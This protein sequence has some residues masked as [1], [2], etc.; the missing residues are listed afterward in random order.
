[1]DDA[2]ARAERLIEGLAVSR[3]VGIGRVVFFKDHSNHHMPSA[4]VES[5]IESE[6]DRFRSA[7]R[8]CV[9]QLNGLSLA[10][11]SPEHVADILSIQ[12]LIL[13][14]SSFAEK[15]ETS[16]REKRNTAE[17]AVKLVTADHVRQQSAVPD[18][19]LREKR[20][21]IEDVCRRMLS[22]LS[23][24]LSAD[25]SG[26]TGAVVAAYELRPSEIIELSRHKPAGIVTE[27]GG[28]TSHS[29]ILA[30]EFMIPMVSGV[31]GVSRII[32]ASEHTIVDGESGT[33]VLSPSL[34]TLDRYA[35]RS[36]GVGHFHQN[37]DAIESSLTLDKVRIRIRANVDIPEAYHLAKQFGAEGIGLFRSE[38]LIASPGS[39]PDEE[40]QF[41]AYRQI[42]EVAGDDRVRIRTFDIGLDRLRDSGLHSEINPSLGLRSIRLS[43]REQEH[44]RTQ[45]RAILRAS[46]DTKIDIVLPMV[47]G[48]SEVVRAKT[49]IDEERASLISRDVEVGDPRVGAM[50]E[51]PSGV[52]T[53]SEIAREV[54]FL[55]LGTNDLV[56]YLLAVDRDNDAVAEWYQTLHP[57]VMRAVSTVIGA[58]RTASVPMLI[59]GEMAGSPFYV[60]LL[61]GLGARELSMN[62]NSISQIR[63]LISGITSE[64]CAELGDIV[65]ADATAETVEQHVREFYRQNW[66]DLFP[67]GFLDAKH[68]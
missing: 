46:V 33:I 53:A 3:G 11:D 20:L 1:M 29:S 51:V 31:T 68:R 4:I 19:H 58:A 13:E 48:V 22:V 52:F 50:I 2:A 27:R 57:A 18:P 56:Q 43:F 65:L 62:V 47:A 60:P 66:K 61:I 59:C 64:K 7:V 54:D 45:I 37:A 5:D 35:A 26:Y 25:S 30:R 67:T 14:Q 40:E 44:F 34:G 10:K 39:I 24:P 21:D 9:D 17:L 12:L 49:I 32:R 28:W 55:A 23:G 42:A 6:I 41:S 63:H 15:V 16:I 38:S 36:S 8:D